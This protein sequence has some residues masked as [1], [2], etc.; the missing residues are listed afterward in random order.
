MKTWV[1]FSLRNPTRSILYNR[2]SPSIWRRRTNNY[3]AFQQTHCLPK[4]SAAPKMYKKMLSECKFT[5]II[6]LNNWYVNGPCIKTC[7]VLVMFKSQ[8]QRQYKTNSY[9]CI[10]NIYMDMWCNVGNIQPITGPSMTASAANLFLNMCHL[11]I[12]FYLFIYY[13]SPAHIQDKYSKQ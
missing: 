13:A 12:Y 10:E 11:Y 1:F 3:G 8:W 5:L 4:Q 6:M 7:E 9:L 2:L